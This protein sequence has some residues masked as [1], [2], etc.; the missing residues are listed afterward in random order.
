MS[1][2]QKVLIG[3]VMLLLG[4]LA[5]LTWGSLG[6]GICIFGMITVPFICLWQKHINSDRESDFL[7]DDN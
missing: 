2:L 5:A 6:S 7:E 1:V 4:F 3:A